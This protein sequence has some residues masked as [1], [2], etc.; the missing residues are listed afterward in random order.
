MDFIAKIPIDQKLFFISSVLIL[1]CGFLMKFV[2]GRNLRLL[3]SFLPG[4]IFQYLLYGNSSFNIWVSCISNIYILK[5][6]DRK[7]LG[8]IS[9]IYNFIH[10]SM[11]HLYRIFFE[12]TDH[13]IEISTIFMMT[14]CKFTGFGASYSNCIKENLS[15]EQEK[16]KIKNFTI[17]EFFSFTFFFPTCICGPFIEF[18]DF[19][20]FI[21][22]KG[23][24]A[25]IPST[26]FLVLKRYT[27]GL[28]FAA[29]NLFCN[30]YGKPQNIID[31]AGN[32]NFFQKIICYYFGG[33]LLYKYFAA[34][35]VSEAC[36]LASGF[37][38]DGK[39]KNDNNEEIDSFD[40]ARVIEIFKVSTIYYPT[41]FFRHWNISTHVWLKRYLYTSFLSENSSNSEK[42]IAASKTFFVSA[43]WHG[44]HLT[45]FVTFG[46][47]FF[48]TFFENQIRTII[49]SLTKDNY[50]FY[51]K[52]RFD[53]I[54]RILINILMIP[55]LCFLWECLDF[56][57]L[58]KFVSSVYYFATIFIITANIF[59]YLY[60]KIFIK[61]DIIIKEIL[62]KD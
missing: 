30:I 29:L 31:D 46:H 62:K 32:Y 24:Y 54:S 14:T 20:R 56:S 52:I 2:K 12:Y 18:N 37:A 55:Y 11:I 28:I 6:C 47:F 53:W 13:R 7:N 61:K 51:A 25:N 22:E 36:V 48:L 19:I 4:L 9:L 40:K 44:F 38:Y 45:Y 34:F 3:Y 50:S 1:I 58:L 33:L 16:Y 35:C 17:F 23:E 60:I 21:E 49:N 5:N 15:K 26:Y 39:V 57:M 8:K 42:Q 59:A 27:H 10:N 43:F 41:N